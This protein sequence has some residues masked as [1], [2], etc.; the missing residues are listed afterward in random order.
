MYKVFFNEHLLVSGSE[1]QNSFKDNIDEIAEIENVNDFFKLLLK[2]EKSEYVV[3]LQINAKNGESLP[4][5]LAQNMTLI[6]AAGGLVRNGQNDILFIKRLGRW[7]LPKGK[8][9]QNESDREAAIREVEE[10]CGITGLKIRQPLPPT[11][12]IYRSPFIVEKNNWVLKKTSWFEMEYSGNELP[13]PQAEEQIEEVR[14]FTKQQLPVV[15]QNTYASLKDMIGF[16]L[17]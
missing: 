8:I 10:E 4:E 17:D 9:E 16:Y 11:F 1:I 12:H 3:Q 5:L 14:W 7:D 6:P 2:L 13:S 15:L